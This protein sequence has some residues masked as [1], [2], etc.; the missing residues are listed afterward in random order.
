MIRI[1]STRN[2]KQIENFLFDP[3]IHDDLIPDDSLMTGDEKL[4]QLK[5]KF[6]V[7][8]YDDKPAGI[9][10]LTPL[11]DDSAGINLGIK[12]CFRG[13]IGY[14]ICEKM[15]DF[16]KNVLRISYLVARIRHQNKKSLFFARQMGFKP[17][18]QNNIYQYMGVEYG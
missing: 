2:R 16:V 9:C 7:M 10:I 8:K 14:E 11:D 6:F 13:K 5:S 3:D 15:T 4:L 18:G 1:E 17:I 12:K